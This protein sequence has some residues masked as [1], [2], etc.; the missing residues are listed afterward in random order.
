MSKT[1]VKAKQTKPKQPKVGDRVGAISHEDNDNVFFYGYGFY[2]GV[3]TPPRDVKFMGQSI[4]T[5]NPKIE[6]ENGKVVWGCE[7]WWGTEKQINTH[8]AK[9]SKTK[10]IILVDVEQNRKDVEE[11][12]NLADI[13]EEI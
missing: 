10:T 8:L 1:K 11:A 4:T 12:R 6:L 13:E 3:E 9:M 2:R 7:C 5:P